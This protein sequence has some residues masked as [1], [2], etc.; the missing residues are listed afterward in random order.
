MIDS[1]DGKYRFLSNFYNAPVTYN[2]LRYKNSEAAFHA[3][4]TLDEN[5][6][7]KFT[8]LD[9]STSKRLGRSI[10]MREDWLDV[11]EHIMYEVCLAKFTQNPRLKKLLLETGDEILV[12]GNTWNDRFWG[13]CNGRGLN[14]LGETLMRIRDELKDKECAE[15]HS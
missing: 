7:I 9:P 6:R 13:V 10:Q 8:Q 15:A 3:Q 14:R 12:E 1:F 11:R 2:G 5:E 4:K